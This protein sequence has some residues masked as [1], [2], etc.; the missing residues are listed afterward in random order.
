MKIASWV[1]CKQTEP[2]RAKGREPR[3]EQG[4]LGRDRMKGNALG[5]R[6]NT[7]ETKNVSTKEEFRLKET[8]IGTYTLE[9][10]TSERGKSL[11]DSIRMQ[12]HKRTPLDE[13]YCSE[14][15][16]GRSQDMRT[17]YID[18][19]CYKMNWKRFSKEIHAPPWYR[20]RHLLYQIK[21]FSTSKCSRYCLKCSLST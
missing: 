9:N 4:V 1:D 10:Q 20:G 5:A 17:T 13:V 2:P 6:R 11:G 18:K 14:K 7:M 15:K 8:K 12:K 3:R 21:Y 19:K 16:D